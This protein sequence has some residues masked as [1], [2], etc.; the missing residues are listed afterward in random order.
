MKRTGCFALLA[1]I[2]TTLLVIGV[3][4]T[5]MHRRTHSLLEKW[6]RKEPVEA[7]PLFA[8]GSATSMRSLYGP[9]Y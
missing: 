7:R 8:T 2:G 3:I 5:L 6:G 1:S 4:S 9:S